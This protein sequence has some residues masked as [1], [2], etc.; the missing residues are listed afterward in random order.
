[1]IQPTLSTLLAAPQVDAV[2]MGANP[3]LVIILIAAVLFAVSIGIVAVTRYKRCPSNRVL[4]VY[5]KVGKGASSKC[6]HGGAALILPIFQG[7]D[8]LELDPIQI[9]VP[10]QGALSAENIRVNVP[11]FF[12]VAIGTDPVTMQ[13]AAIRLLGLK[14]EEIKGTLTRMF[15]AESAP[16]SGTSIWIGSSSR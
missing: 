3:F 6:V 5:G 2:D 15:S 7:Y 10:L 13:N 14:V 9:E 12:T 4:V 11:S 16:L 1:M 8:Y